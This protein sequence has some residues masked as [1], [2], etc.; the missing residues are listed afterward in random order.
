MIA[1]FAEK[2]ES[3]SI[4]L[5]IF[6]FAFITV[7]L[8]RVDPGYFNFEFRPCILDD[9]YLPNEEVEAFLLRQSPYGPSVHPLAQ[10]QVPDLRTLL[11]LQKASI[12]KTDKKLRIVPTSQEKS[13]PTRSNGHFV[14]RHPDGLS[15]FGMDSTHYEMA[16]DSN[17]WSQ[18]FEQAAEIMNESEE[19]PSAPAKPL[20]PLAPF[21]VRLLKSK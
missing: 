8:P 1:Q 4:W 10:A 9:N 2:L 16:I 21:G 13:S 14:A 7:G 12:H 19:I 17:D 18:S 3:F 15:F 20:A 6:V 5:T 11:A